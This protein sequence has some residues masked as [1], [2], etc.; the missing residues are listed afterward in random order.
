MVAA[1]IYLVIQH[2][3]QFWVSS[4]IFLATSCVLKYTWYDTLVKG[5]GYLSD[6]PAGDLE[7]ASRANHEAKP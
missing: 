7:S 5:D 3:R 4:A 6:E 2:W 1:P